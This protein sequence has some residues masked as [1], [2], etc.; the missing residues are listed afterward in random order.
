MY[1]LGTPNVLTV[2]ICHWSCYIIIIIYQYPQDTFHK[3]SLLSLMVRSLRMRCDFWARR[4]YMST[5]CKDTNSLQ[6]REWRRE[7]DVIEGGRVSQ[8]AL[9]ISACRHWLWIRKPKQQPL[10]VS[11][12]STQL[13]MSVQKLDKS[14]TWTKHRLSLAWRIQS[15]L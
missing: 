12:Q 4:D 9:R 2:S 11:T 1:I 14:Y 7:I 13:L 3:K 5:H 6:R 15:L 10:A 8:S